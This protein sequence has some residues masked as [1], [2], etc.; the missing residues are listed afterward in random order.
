MNILLIS[1]PAPRF[2]IPAAPLGLACLAGALP[3]H[4]V[5][6]WDLEAWRWKTAPMTEANDTVAQAC[7]LLAQ[8]RPAV[9]GISVLE[10]T[11]EWAVQLGLA[12]KAAGAVT[13]AGGLLPT[14]LPHC[15]PGVFDYHVRGHGEAPFAALLA[16]LTG[17]NPTAPLPPGVGTSVHEADIACPAPYAPSQRTIF[18]AAN[19]PF[20]YYEARIVS[21]M[22]CVHRC[23]FCANAL[24]SGRQWQPLPAADVIAQIVA[25]W[26]DPHIQ[27]I[28]FSDDQFLGFFPSDSLRALEI[29][30]AAE[31]VTRSR[32]VRWVLQARCDRWLSALAEVPALGVVLSRMSQAFT[33]PA[34]LHMPPV[35]GICVDMGVESFL[36]T[37]LTG[38]DKHISAGENIQA[39]EAAYA[40]DIDVGVYMLPFTYNVTLTELSRE[41][42][43]YTRHVLRHTPTLPAFYA[44]FQELVPYEA[45]PLYARIQQLGLLRGN[46]FAFRDPGAAIFYAL[47]MAEIASNQ[48]QSLPLADAVQRIDALLTLAGMLAQ[49]PPARKLAHTITC[50]GN[51]FAAWYEAL[52]ALLPTMGMA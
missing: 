33:A 36:D 19:H 30:Q 23:A 29:L 44:F 24:L 10:D 16:W 31:R 21:S 15:V 46:A 9:V 49:Y 37:R 12:A 5:Q 18:D 47:S 48:Y 27:Q 41:W 11:L 4:H 39:L 32:P 13:V 35:R 43:L 45:T 42:T 17:D 38:L 1:P 40:L 8:H 6:G 28:A 3:A 50:P 26:A 20:H 22:G 25:A 51:A 7:A 52:V 14:M 34:A 2:I